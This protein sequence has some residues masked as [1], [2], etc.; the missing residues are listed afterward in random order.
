[1]GI[2]NCAPTLAEAIDSI[3]A[4]TYENWE[5]I[6]CD[7]GSA[8]HTY[9]IADSYRQRYPEKIVLLKNEQNMGLNHTLNHCLDH[10][11]GE[12]IARMDGDDISLPERFEKELNYLLTHPE[13][14]IVSS[15]M[16]YFD[17]N[18]QIIDDTV[19]Y[20]IS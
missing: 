16:V 2:Y 4:Q 3:L 19:P 1:M 12:Y 5:L 10:A 13:Y 8:D 18:G 17:E 7:D 20:G 15:P 11:T 14:A 9:N 6:L